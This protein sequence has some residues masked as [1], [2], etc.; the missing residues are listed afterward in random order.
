VVLTRSLIVSRPTRKGFFTTG[1]AVASFGFVTSEPPAL[2]APVVT[3]GLGLS[4]YAG[5]DAGGAAAVIDTY[6][7]G[8]TWGAACAC[9]D[10]D[11]G[12]YAASTARGWT[13]KVGAEAEAEAEEGAEKGVGSTG[14]VSSTVTKLPTGTTPLP[15]G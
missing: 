1:R 15:W 4:A 8:S 10:D 12:W 11:D 7:T 3:A 5:T 9:E 14:P 2:L 13:L 6:S